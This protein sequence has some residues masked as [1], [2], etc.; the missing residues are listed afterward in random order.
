MYSKL[1]LVIGELNSAIQRSMYYYTHLQVQLNILSLK[2]SPNLISPFN[3]RT[4]LEQMNDQLPENKELPSDLGKWLWDY[5]KHISCLTFVDTQQHVIIAD[6]PLMY[7]TQKF[8]LYKTYAIP[9]LLVGKISFSDSDILGYYKIESD[10]FAINH[11]RTRYILMDA[12]QVQGCYQ[13]YSNVCKVREPQ[14]I[15][16]NDNR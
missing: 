13:T 7:Y 10:F 16:T 15:T 14:Y 12:N 4:V 2:L 5:Y 3:L 11:Q 9:S 1:E 8:E 6:I